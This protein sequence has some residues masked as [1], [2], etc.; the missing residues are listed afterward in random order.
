[1]LVLYINTVGGFERKK[2]SKYR[3]SFMSV[4]FFSS[5]LQNKTKFSS[6][7][8]GFVGS[9]YKGH[10]SWIGSAC[11]QVF[12]GDRR[13]GIKEVCHVSTVRSFQCNHI[14]LWALSSLVL[15]GKPRLG[16]AIWRNFWHGRIQKRWRGR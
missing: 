11:A 1:M 8:S 2:F 12:G 16:T 14:T 4:I 10:V 6:G 7:R 15:S 5:L 3:S 9:V 13:P